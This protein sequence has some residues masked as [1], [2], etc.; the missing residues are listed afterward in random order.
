MLS[1]QEIERIIDK[2]ECTFIAS[3][4]EDGY[5][6]MKAM[7][8]H[9]ERKGLKEFYFTTNASALRTGHYRVNPCASIYY[10]QKGPVRYIGILFMGK[11]EILVD[12]EIKSR[13]WR[14]GDHMFYCK[15]ITD[16]DYCVLKFTA[17]SGRCYCDLQTDNFTIPE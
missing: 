12:Q 5:P 4:G 8:R 2:Q 6:Y 9:R 3:H 1:L 10:T 16:P 15:G 11:M 14:T 17:E 7:L 13:I